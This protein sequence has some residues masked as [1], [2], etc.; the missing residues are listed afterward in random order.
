MKSIKALGMAL[1][2]MSIIL[3]SCSGEDGQTGPTGPTGPAG[4]T[5]Q[6]TPGDPGADGLACW[7][8]DGSGTA[9]LES[10]DINNDGV[11]D[12]LDCQGVPGNDGLNGQDGSDKPNMDFYFQDG[13]K[14]YSGTVDAT[15]TNINGDNGDNGTISQVSF[16][17]M[18]VDRRYHVMRFD[19]ISEQITT[20]LVGQG[21][22]CAEAF[23]M[24]RAT[25]YIY[26]TSYTNDAD[27]LYLRVGFYN[28]NDPLFVE[29][30]TIWT[31]ANGTDAWHGTGGESV[32]WAGPFVGTDN[33]AV[34]FDAGQGVSGSNSGW[35]PIQL[36]RSVVENWICDGNTNKGIRLRLDGDNAVNGS[37]I[38]FPSSENTNADLRPLLVIETEDVEPSATTKMAPSAKTK[39]WENLSYE[40]KMA[41]LYR[42]FAAKGL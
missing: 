9:D 2:G 26:I 28:A 5:G 31:M 6:G 24:N 11:V 30:E 40:E 32:N 27:P 10:E 12:A 15:I 42:Y 29:A 41:P 33:Y 35:F 3:A 17:E 38:S 20:V 37:T 36:P 14:G 8:L 16:A 34:Q 4:P 39:D 25:L 23:Y 22:N 19:D 18:A 1:L 13:F 7:D 21:E